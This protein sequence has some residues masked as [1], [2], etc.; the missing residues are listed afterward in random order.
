MA[1][2]CSKCKKKIGLFSR[3]Y[4]CF[5]CGKAFCSNCINDL[6]SNNSYYFKLLEE[7]EYVVFDDYNFID[8]RKN[9]ACSSCVSKFHEKNSRISKA[10]NS[11]KEIELLP[12]TYK[13]RRNILGP[14]VEISSI[15]HKDWDMCDDDL[16][17]LARYY[18]CDIVM[19]IR[20]HRYVST[21]EEDKDN[22]KGTYTKTLVTWS[23]TGVAFKLK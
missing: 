7:P 3:T 10:L 2:V 1:I 15:D 8:T 17:F 5:Y 18:D 16:R 13:G 21:Y 14:G 22:G 9:I 19:D 11:K 12:Y 4:I 20:K 6:K 23:K